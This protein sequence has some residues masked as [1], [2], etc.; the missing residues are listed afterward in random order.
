M[1]N[2]QNSSGTILTLNAN[3]F[4]IGGVAIDGPGGL[5]VGQASGPKAT[6]SYLAN[7]FAAPVTFGTAGLVQNT[8]RELTPMADP[9]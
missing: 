6:I 2:E 1:G 5:V 4:V 3:S 8:W 9:A 7:A